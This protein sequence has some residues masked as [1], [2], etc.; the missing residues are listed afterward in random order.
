[1]A[2][3]VTRRVK[4]AMVM[5]MD[6][7][8]WRQGKRLKVNDVSEALESLARLLLLAKAE[9]MVAT[10][11]ASRQWQDNVKRSLGRRTCGTLSFRLFFRPRWMSGYA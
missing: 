9:S 6:V 3:R 8:P 11:A 1:M 2:P 7:S 10:T 5:I 4:D